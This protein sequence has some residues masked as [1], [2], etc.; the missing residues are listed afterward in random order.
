LHSDLTDFDALQQTHNEICQ[1]MPPIAGVAQGA[2]VLRDGPTRDMTLDQMTGVLDP[3]VQGSLNLD[4]LFQDDSLDFFVFFSS[5]ASVVGH[6]GQANYCAANMFMHGLALQR[7]RRGLAASVLDLGAVLGTGYI[8]RELTDEQAK[9]LLTRGF[10]PVSE[11]DVHYAVSEAINASPLDAGVEPEISTAM[12]RKL[13]SEPNRP[14]WYSNT[15]YSYMTLRESADGSSPSTGKE[16]IS[17][18][19]QLANATSRDEVQTT[20]TGQNRIFTSFQNYFC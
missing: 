7:R 18:S 8:S 1:S 9:G 12:V 2:M 4:S 16:G 10:M 13:A 14:H 17:I 11:L 20:L 19:D 15:I 5:T 3:K 6:V